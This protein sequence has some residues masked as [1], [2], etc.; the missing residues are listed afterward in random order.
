[1]PIEWIY[2]LVLFSTV[3]AGVV[4]IIGASGII[5]SVNMKTVFDL[6][7]RFIILTRNK[8]PLTRYVTLRK[9]IELEEINSKLHEGIAH[10]ADILALPHSSYVSPFEKTWLEDWQLIPRKVKE[11]QV[12][13]SA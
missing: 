6:E 2:L 5:G 1:V 13:V 3:D 8:P 4:S 9:G 11:D 12:N 10:E 7:G